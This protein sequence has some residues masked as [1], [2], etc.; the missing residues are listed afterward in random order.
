MPSRVLVIHGLTDIRCYTGQPVAAMPEVLK[1]GDGKSMLSARSLVGSFLFA[2][3]ISLFLSGP[4]VAAAAFDFTTVVNKARELS[5]QPYKAPPQAPQFLRDLSYNQYQEIRFKPEES[6][7]QQDGSR[8]QIM[9]MPP[10][11]YYNHT[12][13]LHVV[14]PEGVSPVPFDKNVFNYPNEEFARRIP[15]DLG[16]A[17][18]KLTYPLRQPDIQN[19]FLVFAGA[20]YFRGVGK[21]NRFGISARGIAVDTGLRSGEEFPAFVE[22]WLER[23]PANAESMVVYGLLD[24]PSI[25]GA[26][27][28]RIF[29]GEETRVEITAKLFTRND[30]ALLGVAPL[31]SMFY[32]GENTVRPGG[33]WRPQVHDSDGLLLHDGKSGEWLWRPLINPKSLR[34]SYLQTDNIRGFGLLQRDTEFADFEDMGARYELR[35]SAWVETEGDWG[36]GEVVLVEIPTRSET[37]DNIVAF[38]RPEAAVKAGQQLDYEYTVVFG[39]PTVPDQPSARAVQTFVGDGNRIGGGDA[40]GAYRII[41]DFAGGLLDTLDPGASVVSKVTGGKNVEVIEHFVEYLEPNGRWRLSMLVRPAP[42]E[43]LSLRAFL[44]LDDKPLTETWTY[45]LPA[46]EDIRAEAG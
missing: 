21:D 37:N 18:F 25:T 9:M 15:A 23:P 6:L 22:F 2:L 35:P 30:I 44:S 33:E 42:S 26:Y 41:I 45:E 17:G 28:F 4:A 10:G 1:Y 16:Y 5:T 3:S 34:M 43:V 38:W 36:K 27:R 40:E 39:G 7:W 8:F 20:S 14:G 31:T 19:Q 32:Y 12:V 11:M 46:D 29:P 24:G 13:K